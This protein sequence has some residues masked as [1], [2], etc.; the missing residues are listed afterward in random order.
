MWTC[1]THEYIDKDKNLA[2]NDKENLSQSCRLPHLHFLLRTSYLFL[3]VY[4]QK[5]ECLAFLLKC[6]FQIVQ[7]VEVCTFLFIV[8]EMEGCWVSRSSGS[9]GL[10][11]WMASIKNQSFLFCNLETN[12]L[13]W[14]LCCCPSSSAVT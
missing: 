1:T 3:K 14:F 2:D 13:Y 9:M 11:I 7:R 8:Q 12:S 6:F 4:V 5:L 10:L